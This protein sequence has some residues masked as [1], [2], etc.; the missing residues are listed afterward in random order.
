MSQKIWNLSAGPAI[1][2]DVVLKE[3]QADL[4]DYKNTGMS[5]MEM[6]HRSSCFQAIID[7]AEMLIRE[8]LKVPDNY[9]V[10]F[11]QGGATL[12]FSAIPMNLK[13]RAKAAYIDTGSWSTK[14]IIEAER[15]GYDVDILASSKEQNY[16]HIP[17]FSDLDFSGYDYVHITSNNTIVGSQYS[18]FP[19]TGATPLVADMSSDILSRPIDINQFG[20]IYAGAQK[21]IGPSGLTLVIIREDLLRR[22]S[23]E[24]PI[25]LNYQLQADKGSMYNTPPT[26]AIYAAMLVC[27]WLKG[28]GGL[29]AMAGL[30][31][32][33]AKLI[34]DY[35]DQSALFANHIKPQDRS[36]MNVTFTTGDQ[37]KDAAF[38]EAAVQ[39][40]FLNIKGHR[41]VGGMRASIYNAFPLAGV[42]ALI[43]FMKKYEKEVI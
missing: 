16:D 32:D 18:S 17:Q 39:T 9:K 40:G 20:L 1:M 3:I 25:Y 15:L 37:A 7:E 12:Q 5:V 13:Q 35:L 11:M 24:L 29:E 36:K 42:Q 28:Q 22:S 30:N 10:L 14:A 21:N 41:S 19:Q 27:R 23:Q 6:S 2:P 33:K 34:Y 8:L 4:L 43:D 31:L 26:F 38:V